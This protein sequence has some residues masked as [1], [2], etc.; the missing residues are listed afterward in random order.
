[1]KFLFFLSVERFSND[2][3][4]TRAGGESRISNKVC[5]WELENIRRENCERIIGPRRD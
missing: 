3:K 4:F 5:T 2:T 1:M